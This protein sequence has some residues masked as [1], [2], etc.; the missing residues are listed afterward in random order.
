MWLRKCGEISSFAKETFIKWKFSSKIKFYFFITISIFGRSLE[1]YNIGE[2]N[3]YCWPKFPFYKIFCQ[4]WKFS[5]ILA[6]TFIYSRNFSDNNLAKFW[7]KFS[8][9]PP[10]FLKF[11][12]FPYNMVKFLVNNLLKNTRSDKNISHLGITN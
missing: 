2:A 12:L 6:I 10:K 5:H 7:P 1:K 9:L 8:I 3:K 11:R 4:N